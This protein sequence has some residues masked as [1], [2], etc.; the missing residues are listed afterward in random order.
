[1]R[2]KNKMTPIRE[3]S[4]NERMLR[5]LRVLEGL[6]YFLDDI[7]ETEP[8]TPVEHFV[9]NV[10]MIAHSAAGKCKT[11][12]KGDWLDKI[13]EYEKMLKEVNIMDVEKELKEAE[14]AKCRE[15]GSV[16]DESHSKVSN[17]QQQ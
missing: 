12:R 9:H 4:S 17:L 2:R 7:M 16:Y 6:T 10:Y 13:E 15:S 8:K 5:A 1:M 14:Q 3:C 11:C